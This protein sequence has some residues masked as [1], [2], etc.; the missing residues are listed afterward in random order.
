MVKTEAAMKGAKNTTN[1]RQYTVMNF[2]ILKQHPT[3]G[4]ATFASMAIASSKPFTL[5]VMLT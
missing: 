5:D 2:V 3:L 4:D 1:D